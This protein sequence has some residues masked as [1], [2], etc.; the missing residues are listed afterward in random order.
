[1]G[2]FLVGALLVAAAMLRVQATDCDDF[3]CAQMCYEPKDH[4]FA[5][6]I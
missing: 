3:P 5:F 4:Q 6:V 1:M 2:F